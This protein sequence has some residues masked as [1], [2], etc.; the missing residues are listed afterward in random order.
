MQNQEPESKPEDA[1]EPRDEGLDETTCSQCAEWRQLTDDVLNTLKITREKYGIGNRHVMSEKN[2]EIQ[3]LRD[4]LKFI[5]TNN[6]ANAADMRYRAACALE[7]CPAN[8]KEM[9]PPLT[10]SVETGGKS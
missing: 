8:D 10:G 5:A 1:E 6:I 4:A 2:R 3:V 7:F 9:T